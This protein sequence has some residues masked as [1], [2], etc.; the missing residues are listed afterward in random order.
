[1]VGRRRPLPQAGFVKRFP[2]LPRVADKRAILED[3]SIDLLLIACAPSDRA[4]FAIEAMRRGKDATLDKS[5]C[6]PAAEL[7]ALRAAQSEKGRIWSVDFSERFEVPAVTEAVELVAQGGI[8]RIRSTTGL[9]P[10]RHN[11]HTR[12]PWFH[13]RK[14]NGGVLFDIGSHR[15]DQFLSFTEYEDAEIVSATSA[16]LAHRDVPDFEDFGEIVQ[17]CAQG[18]GYFRVDSFTPD[19]LPNW[20]DGRLFLT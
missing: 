13:S 12:A 9:E 4:V 14:S 6:V 11:P 1:M 2:D 20:D 16:N 3:G 8:G 17:K 7:A 15:I 5:G 19:A 18:K 10:P